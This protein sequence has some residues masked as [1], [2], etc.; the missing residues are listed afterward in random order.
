MGSL[1]GGL[2]TNGGIAIFKKVTA[3]LCAAVLVVLCASCASK[4]DVISLTRE[5]K[6]ILKKMGDDIQV[7]SETDYP[8][9]VTE[10]QAHIGEYSGQVYQLE[11]VF[12]TTDLNGEETP[13]I[14]R[15]LVHDG[16]QTQCGLPIRYL[17]KE[18]PE[19]SWV[20]I[21]AIINSFEYGGETYTTLETVAVETPEETGSAEL[22]W[23][24]I[25]HSH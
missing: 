25:G 23:D 24:G 3:L 18:V 8:A 22:E 16:E 21:S 14:Y 7:I 5:E 1:V 15:T 12:T 4:P 9:M 10:L 13:F 20:R 19:G 6:G 17:E 2:R 11:G